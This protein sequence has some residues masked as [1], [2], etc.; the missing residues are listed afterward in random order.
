MHPGLFARRPESDKKYSYVKYL[1]KTKKTPYRT[2]R[3]KRREGCLQLGYNNPV[4]APK[5]SSEKS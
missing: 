2:V 3:E 5:E 1:I 4:L